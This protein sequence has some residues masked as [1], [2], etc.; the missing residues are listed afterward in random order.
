MREYS[1]TL[2]ITLMMLA[3]AAGIVYLVLEAGRSF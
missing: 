1:P 2:V 3:Y